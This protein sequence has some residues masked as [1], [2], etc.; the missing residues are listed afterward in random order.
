[1]DTIYCKNC[2]HFCQHYGMNQQK[3]YRLCCGHCTFGRRTKT[4]KPNAKA[5]EHFAPGTTPEEDFVSKEYLSKRLLHYMLH[6][7]LLPQIEDI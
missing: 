5:C 2:T 3:I 6:L 7:D 1:M 4:K